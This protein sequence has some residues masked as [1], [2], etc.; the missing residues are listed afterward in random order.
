MWVIMK[1]IDSAGHVIM[2]DYSIQTHNDLRG[3]ERRAYA[4]TLFNGK[5]QM[6][7]MVQGK[8]VWM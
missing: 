6:M 3:L 5:K 7:D 1:D 4:G 8:V 2:G